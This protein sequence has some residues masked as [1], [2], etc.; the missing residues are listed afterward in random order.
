[1]SEKSIKRSQVQDYL[2]QALQAVLST[3]EEQWL[4]KKSKLLSGEPEK[5]D[6][7]LTFSGVAR[8]V[9]HRPL[10]LSPEMQEEANEICEEW[11]PDL[12]TADQ[13]CRV[14]F[15]LTC[16]PET[17]KEALAF[18]RDVF[19]TADM[20]EQVAIFSALPL[21][22]HPAVYRKLARE[23]LRTNMAPVFDAVALHNPYP[24]NYFDE[25]AWNH[26]FLKAAFMGR[27]L[28]KITG[29][30][31]RANAELARMILDYVHERWSAGREVSPEIWRP[32]RGFLTDEH[33]E[34]LEKLDR[35]PDEIQRA[36]AALTRATQ[37]DI[38]FL[39]NNEWSWEKIGQEWGKQFV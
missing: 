7:H 19:D 5:S 31:E 11:R 38:I 16:I 30:A 37:T 39:D 17:E 21:L 14:Y 33:Q 18:I 25:D 34:A 9:E 23:G 27:P 13:A 12:W 8:F 4:E 6:F 1:M 10:D 15:L 22:P 2:K 20:K 24:K 36:A 26:L 29:V 28:Y 3:Q 32:T 35:H